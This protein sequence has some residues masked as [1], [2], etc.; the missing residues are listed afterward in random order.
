MN[1]F[2]GGKGDV[3]AMA[4]AVDPS[5][6]RNRK[7]GEESRAGDPLTAR[8]VRPDPVAEDRIP[9]GL[10]EVLAQLQCIEDEPVG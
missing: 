2:L 4:A 3:E 10:G 8:E 1:E 7:A 6:Y 5:L 9:L